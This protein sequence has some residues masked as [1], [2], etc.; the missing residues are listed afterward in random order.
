MLA[1]KKK[2]YNGSIMTE[3]RKPPA[4]LNLGGKTLGRIVKGLEDLGWTTNEDDLPAIDRDI[5]MIG[6]NMRVSLFWHSS[7]NGRFHQDSLLY[8]DSLYG[9]VLVRQCP[10]SNEKVISSTIVQS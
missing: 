7:G 6:G 5:M 9:A 8:R 10:T 4:R 1:K 2:K 3:V